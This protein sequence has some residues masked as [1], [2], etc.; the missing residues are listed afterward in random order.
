M[1]KRHRVS[2]HEVTQPLDESY[3]LIPLTQGQ[4]AIVDAAD[5]EWLSKW[6]W[7]AHW[8]PTTHSFYA[9]TNIPVDGG[10]WTVKMHRL[11]LQ[12]ARGDRREGDHKNGDTL[13]YRR[14]NLRIA[15]HR[16]NCENR[17]RPHPRNTSGFK[18]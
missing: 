8:C 10:Y 16:Q 13:D 17:R 11:I 14:N 6:H 7:Y 15:E 12:L 5:Y 1:Y 3:R 9:G 18:G 2:R 4:N